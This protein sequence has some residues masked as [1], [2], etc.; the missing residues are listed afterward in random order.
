MT[1]MG[2][3]WWEGRNRGQRRD[4]AGKRRN[5]WREEGSWS[6]LPGARVE[7]ERLAE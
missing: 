2:Q 7:P 6:L 1:A 4:L 3:V 5:L